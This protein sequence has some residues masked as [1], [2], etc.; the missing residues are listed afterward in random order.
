MMRSNNQVG[1]IRVVIIGGGFCGL[2]AAFYL[3]RGGTAVTVL[4]ADAEV[5]GLAG[6]FEVGG[7]R[8]EKFYHHWFTSDCYVMRLLSEL[9]RED[10]I[11]T[12]PNS[13]RHLSREPL[14][15]ISSPL[16]L[17]RFQ[18]LSFVNRIRRGLLALKAR[19]VRDWQ[20]LE[21]RTAADW[22]IEM[23]DHRSIR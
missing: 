4:E 9:G 7:R 15:Q 1:N 16:D 23:A 14:L 20:A 5:G 10:Q 8:L 17:V 12:R 22:L 11:V 3:A 6:T 19:R 18:P 21:H 13:N 2:A